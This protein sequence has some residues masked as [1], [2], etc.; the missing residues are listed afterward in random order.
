MEKHPSPIPLSKYGKRELSPFAAHELLYDYHREAL[1]PERMEGVREQLKKHA[2]LKR[3]LARMQSA[4]LYLSLLGKAVPPSDAIEKID[5]PDTYLSVLLKKTNYERWPLAIRW[6]I[7]AAVVLCVFLAVLIVMPWNQVLNFGLSPQGREI[8][9]A[10]VDHGSRSVFDDGLIPISSDETAG[11]EDEGVKPPTPVAAAPAT[12]PSVTA[13]S[14]V[15]PGRTPPAASPSPSKAS[16]ASPAPTPPTTAKPIAAEAFKKP[17]EGAL[18]RGV[19]RVTNLDA[20]GPKIV[21]KIE[22][23]G[24]RKAGQVELGWKKT[25]TSSYFHFT[26]PQAKYDDLIHFLADYGEP[27]IQKEKHPRVMPEG[28]VRLIIEVEEAEK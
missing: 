22:E 2:H 25:A 1:D 21:E 19:L 5:E 12:P 26:M 15:P 13:P 7:E 23:L 3:D 11:F 28:I 4:D 17:G 10:E 16:P 20:T 24:G 9:L 8:I 6:G 18:Y 14:A 27:R